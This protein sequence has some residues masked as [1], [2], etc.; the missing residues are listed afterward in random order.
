MRRKDQEIT[1]RSEID[2]II[3]KSQVF[4]L[5]MVDGDKPYIVPL[6][7]GYDGKSIYF[8]CA[9]DGKKTDVLKKNS[10]V[11]FEFEEVGPLEESDKPCNWGIKYRSII[12]SGK[13]VLLEDLEEKKNG[14]DL[15][16]KQYTDTPFQ[17]EDRMVAAVT[18]MRIDIEEITGKRSS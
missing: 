8:H 14:L 9:R 3:S 13:A 2:E 12:G 4:R 6:C 1:E 15:V 18:V 10:N 17:F 7:L 16:M 11:C 5:A